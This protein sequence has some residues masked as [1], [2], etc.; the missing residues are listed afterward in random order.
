MKLGLSTDFGSPAHWERVVGFAREHGVDRVVFWG[1]YSHT[2]FAPPLLYPS[3]PALV[4]GEKRA[5]VRR[6]QERLQQAARLAGDAGLEFWYCFQVLQL[7][8]A[9]L[10]RTERPDLFNGAGEPA[11]EGEAIY[12]LLR[13][14]LAELFTLAPNLYGIE[15]WVMECAAVR[16]SQLKH[17]AR[18]AAEI[19][20]RIVDTVQVDVQGRGRRLAVDL[21]TAG[22]DPVAR[23]ALLAAAR[24]HP[25]VLVS[26][27]NVQGDF[28][29]HLPFNP[30]LERAAATNPIQVHFDLNGEYW[31]RNFVPTA[32]FDQY[33][34]HLERARA[35]GAEYVDG[36]VSTG[37]DR[38]SPHGNVLPLRRR[39]YPLLAGVDERSALPADAEVTA[40]D[41]LGCMNAEFFCRHAHDL[42][43]QPE[44]VITGVL[45]REFGEE[46]AALTPLFRALQF[47]LG[48]LFYV[49]RN[50]FGAQSVPPGNDWVL[51]FFA[52]DAHVA[53]L[54]GS[55]FPA[56]EIRAECNGEHRA[57]YP[58][59]PL[60]AGHHCAGVEAMLWEKAEAVAEADAMLETVRQTPL[61]EPG[62]A[63]LIR[64]FE[65]LVLYARSYRALFEALA[66]QTLLAQGIRRGSLPDPARLDASVKELRALADAWQARFHP[67][68]FGGPGLVLARWASLHD[69]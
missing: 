55:E 28:E 57:A 8:D 2:G 32:A 45:R 23:E 59:W 7:P 69:A 25:D 19:F 34:A 6:I 21:H 15:L 27:D 29:L 49:D 52:F 61:A 54:P 40:T 38:W 30:V 53:A 67:T 56:E 39:Y 46:A 4:P 58:G 48:K 33:I 42:A 24:R 11:M 60:P 66:H 68:W 64:Q 13:E 51:H 62:R 31:G 20:G 5:E 17:Q 12:A 10:A 26:G 37:H 44:E 63:F 3:C 65:T 47:T 16:I 36:R 43:V 22:G 18:P 14:Q 9:E 35:L 1:D 50:Y 41:T